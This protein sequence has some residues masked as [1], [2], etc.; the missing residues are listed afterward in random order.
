[1]LPMPF[2][3]GFPMSCPLNPWLSD[4]AGALSKL[5]NSSYVCTYLLGMTASELTGPLSQFQSTLSTKEDTLR[6][7]REQIPVGNGALL[8]L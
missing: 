5:A 7:I 1:M 2:E 3:T 6:L 8:K 4:A